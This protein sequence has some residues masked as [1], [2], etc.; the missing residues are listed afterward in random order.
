MRNNRAM[1][2]LV[3]VL[4]LDDVVAFDLGVPAQVFGSARDNGGKRL[5]EVR[6][7]TKDGAPVR[8]SAGF[9]VL[10]DHGLDALAAADTVVVPGIHSGPP[11]TDGTLD[12]V[13][14]R[15]LVAAR[16]RGARVMSICT[17]A[18]VLAAAG[19]LDGRAATTHWRHADRFR[20]LYPRVRLDPDVL[21]VDDGDV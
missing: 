17:A 13:V 5:Y 18:S 3:A 15:A 11:L 10:P 14:G 6:T 20:R 1:A 12:P 8:T 21:F 9:R 19:L 16:E 4:A 2:H 7:C